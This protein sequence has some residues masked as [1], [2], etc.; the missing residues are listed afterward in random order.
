MRRLR[1]DKLFHLPK[2]SSEDESL[3][4]LADLHGEG[5]KTNPLV[6]LE[7]EEI[8]QQVYFERTEGAKSYL[9][10]LKPGNPRR[11]LLGMS[12]QMWS[13]L[14]GMNIMM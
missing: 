1:C 9:D 14:C 12:L 3:Q 13:Q 8:K 11:V 10:L 7:Y 5:D 6:A 2:V 4:V